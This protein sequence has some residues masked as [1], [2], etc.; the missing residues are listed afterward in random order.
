MRTGSSPLMRGKPVSVPSDEPVGGLIPTHAGKTPACPSPFYRRWAHPRSRGENTAIPRR[1][2]S[3]R[4][5]SPLTRGKRHVVPPRRIHQGLIPAHAGKTSASPY[6]TARK[7]AHPRSYGENGFIQVA[8]PANEGSSP[9]MRGK[10]DTAAA[11]VGA[12]GLIPAHAGKT[13]RSAHC[14]CRRGAHPRSRGENSTSRLVAAAGAGS[15]PL[16]R[17][18]HPTPPRGVGERGLIP[19]HAGKTR[20]RRLDGFTGWAHPRSRGEN[21]VGPVLLRG[22]RGSS[23]LTRGKQ[24]PSGLIAARVGLIPAHAGKTI[25]GLS[26]QWGREAHP[27]SRGENAGCSRARI[28]DMGSSPLTRG[29][30]RA[31]AGG[32]PGRGLIPAHAGKTVRRPPPTSPPGAHPRS[33]GENRNPR[34]RCIRGG[35]S[36][37]LTRGKLFVGRFACGASGL[38]PAH[39]G[40][41]SARSL[42]HASPWAHPRSRGENLLVGVDA[43]KAQGSSPLTRGKQVFANQSRSTSG[44]IPAHAGKTLVSGSKLSARAAHPRSRGENAFVAITRASITGSSPLTRGKHPR[45]GSRR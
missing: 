42:G 20:A 4:G 11:A 12:A 29:K 8:S 22:R 16:T 39:A 21:R 18:K 1:C 9:L 15:S 30:L 36:S 31:V 28:R 37:P 10:R 38:I 35:G 25:D 5:S 14:A 32:R 34:S 24:F 23:P 45:A 33:R 17:G 13:H 27:R 7:W 19:A 40:K 3:R 41:T 2:V 43:L 6:G 26:F 44:L